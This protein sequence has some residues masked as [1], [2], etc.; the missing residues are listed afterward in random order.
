M[1]DLFLFNKKK[2]WIYRFFCFFIWVWFFFC[3]HF[4]PIHDQSSWFE[5][6]AENRSVFFLLLLLRMIERQAQTTSQPAIQVAM[7][8]NRVRNIMCWFP[9]LIIPFK[10]CIEYILLVC[11]SVCMTNEMRQMCGNVSAPLH[12]RA[13]MRSRSLIYYLR[14]NTLFQKSFQQ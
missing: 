8:V 1:I 9:Q 4:S 12:N 14:A 6:S 5:F 13:R 10:H 11:L 2:M 7:V 3:I